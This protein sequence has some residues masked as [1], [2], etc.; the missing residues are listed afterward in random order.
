MAAGV[1]GASTTGWKHGASL[2]RPSP[3]NA[4]GVSGVGY[5]Y[6]S[7]ND[8]MATT[9]ATATAMTIVAKAGVASTACSPTAGGVKVASTPIFFIFQSIMGSARRLGCNGIPVRIVRVS[10]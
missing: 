1:R 2:L 3:C 6:N 5:D 10:N 9:M 8:V 7:Y 4:G